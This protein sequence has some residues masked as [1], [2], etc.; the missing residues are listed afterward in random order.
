MSCSTQT[1]LT[2]LF[3]LLL[4]ILPFFVFEKSTY[5]LE[6][7]ANQEA[8]IKLLAHACYEAS[9]YEEDKIGKLMKSELLRRKLKY[10]KPS[11]C[12][13]VMPVTHNHSK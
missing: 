12:P 9:H 3:S 10:T 1:S 6:L 7:R 13:T 8:F 11:L 4:L 2:W 5:E